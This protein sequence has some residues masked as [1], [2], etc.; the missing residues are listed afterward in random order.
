M[1]AIDQW[2][3]DEEKRRRGNYG[4]S[5]TVDNE[6][7]SPS[8]TQNT[9]QQESSGSAIDSWFEN[10]RKQQEQDKI[11]QELER[12][13]KE[14][15]AKIQEF[16][17][18]LEQAKNERNFLQKIFRT[19][20]KKEKELAE[21]KAEFTAVTF[22]KKYT[23]EQKDAILAQK[24]KDIKL[25]DEQYISLREDVDN[26]LKY[27]NS[28]KSITTQ[29]EESLNNFQQWQVT[30]QFD[31]KEYTRNTP[32][33]PTKELVAQSNTYNTQTDWTQAYEYLKKAAK[34]S[35]MSE[36]EYAR[37]YNAQISGQMLD[38]YQKVVGDASLT[39]DDIINTTRRTGIPAVD[40][41]QIRVE[42]ENINQYLDR[43]KK[44]YDEY[45][46]VREVDKVDN[47][48]EGLEVARDKILGGTA[49]F[50]GDLF[51]SN[52]EGLL[53]I[54]QLKQLEQK[55]ANGE[56]LTTAET[57]RIVLTS[58]LETNQQ[59]DR[60]WKTRVAQ[61]TP[62]ALKM[63]GEMA[64][65][66]GIFNA[67]QTAVKTTAVAAT[68]KISYSAAKEIVEAA[69]SE[70]GKTWI[71]TL[72]TKGAK[73]GLKQ[74]MSGVA[75]AMVAEIPETIAKDS[76]KIATE[77]MNNNR[78]VI[79]FSDP[80]TE[81]EFISIIKNDE[82]YNSDWVNDLTKAFARQYFMN[83]LERGAGEVP[84]AI[85][86]EGADKLKGLII[87][88]YMSQKG[89]QTLEEF[90]KVYDAVGLQG[91]F[92][93]VFEEYAQD[94]TE[95]IID[96]R[97]FI[98][99]DPD[100]F[101]DIVAQV[102]VLQ[103]GRA[104]SVATTV[105]D[106]TK[107]LI[108]GKTFETDQQVPPVGGAAPVDTRV[109]QDVDT[110]ITNTQTEDSIQE[111]L[112]TKAVVRQ[113]QVSGETQTLLT[114]P[115]DDATLL[116]KAQ[117]LSD[118]SKQT[119]YSLSSLTELKKL[120][121]QA[122][123]EKTAQAI[124][125]IS[126]SYAD[127]LAKKVADGSVNIGQQIDTQL[128]D[129]I[130]EIS[131]DE[132]VQEGIKT[133][134]QQI[135]ETPN[136]EY[137]VQEKG[138]F[139]EIKNAQTVKIINEADT[140]IYKDAESKLYQ[141]VEA[142]SGMAIAE[143]STKSTAIEQATA[144]LNKMGVETFQNKIQEA[145]DKK[146]V[147]PRYVKKEVKKVIKKEVKTVDKVQDNVQP[148]SLQEESP[149]E[150]AG[151][152]IG[153]KIKVQGKLREVSEFGKSARDSQGVLVRFTDG[154]YIT[155]DKAQEY[156][157]QKQTK[158][159]VKK[160]STQKTKEAVKEAEETVKKLEKEK[161]VDQNQLAKR[162]MDIGKTNPEVKKISKDLK[163]FQE[164]EDY[165][166]LKD[167][168]KMLLKEAGITHSTLESY[169]D[170]MV[171]MYGEE[172]ATYLEDFMQ[173]WTAAQEIIDTFT[174]QKT[175]MINDQLRAEGFEIP[176]YR[177]IKND[178]LSSKTPFVITN[179][180]SNI[181]K[182]YKSSIELEKDYMI[183][184]HGGQ[185]EIIGGKLVTG[186][187]IAGD[188]TEEN[189]GRG[190]D[191]GGIF[192]T[193][194]KDFASIFTR[195]SEA[196]AG[197]VHTFLVKTKEMFDV[198]NPQHYQKLKDF[199]GKTY[200]DIDGEDLV[201][202][203][204]MLNFMV[205]DGIMDWATFDS[206]VIEAL[207]FKGVVVTE[208]SDYDNGKPLMT[209]VLFE[210]G[211]DS[212]HY[213][214][215]D[216]IESISDLYKEVKEGIQIDI[217]HGGVL[218]PLITF[219]NITGENLLLADKAGGLIAPS[220][221][222]S[223]PTNVPDGFGEITLI[224]GRELADPEIDYRN[225]LYSHDVYSPRVTRPSYDTDIDG[226]EKFFYEDRDVV[227][228]F[229]E[230]D[231]DAYG[232]IE[233]A[234]SDQAK[235]N[236]FYAA[237]KSIGLMN[238]YAK[239]NGI[240]M[241]TVNYYIKAT[242]ENT[243]DVIGTREAFRKEYRDQYEQWIRDSFD[244]YFGEPYV[245]VGGKKLP[246]TAENIVLS[247]F[248]KGI[249]GQEGGMFTGLNKIKG[250]GAKDYKTIEQAKRDSYGRLVSEKEY[251]E[252]TKKQ[253]DDFSKYQDKLQKY[254]RFGQ[255]GYSSILDHNHNLE[256]AMSDYAKKSRT[257][258]SF[259]SAFSRN[260]Y[261]FPKDV[262]E[263][264][265]K[266]ADGILSDPVPY[267][268][269]KL[270]R[271]VNI[272]DFEGALVPDMYR[273][274]SPE[275]EE[276]LKK[277]G[278][279]KIIWL[280]GENIDLE[281]KGRLVNENFDDIKYRMSSGLDTI[282]TQEQIEEIDKYNQK[283]FGDTKYNILQELL[284]EDGQKVYGRYLQ[285][286][287]DI[288]ETDA[289]NNYLHEAA[290]KGFARSDINKKAVL[291]EVIKK[292]GKKELEKKWGNYPNESLAKYL[293]E[294]NRREGH[295]GYDEITSMADI[296]RNLD[297]LRKDKQRKL[298]K[299]DK[300]VEEAK[301]WLLLSDKEVSELNE[302]DR[303]DY[304]KYLKPQLEAIAI[305]GL[306]DGE[307][308]VI[309]SGTNGRWVDTDI[310]VA[311]NRGV[312]A[313]TLALIVKES[314]IESTGVEAKDDR[315]ERLLAYNIF[316]ESEYAPAE[317]RYRGSIY[318][319]DVYIWA[320]E[321]LAENFIDYVQG[322]ETFEGR[323]KQFFD[324]LLE[325]IKSLV[326]AESQ[327]KK[328]YREIYTG[329]LSTKQINN[330]QTN[331]NSNYRA[332]ISKGILMSE[333]YNLVEESKKYKTFE[334]FKNAI[335]PQNNNFPNILYHGT[336]EEFDMFKSKEGKRSYGIFGE[337]IVKTNGMFLTVN[338]EYAKNYGKNV[339]KVYPF[340]KNPLIGIS[341]AQYGE[342]TDQKLKDAN[343]IFEPIVEW[344]TYED[345]NGNKKESAQIGT[346]MI[347]YEQDY[348]G[349]KELPLNWINRFIGEDG[350]ID[351]RLLDN[352]EVTNRLVEKGYDGLLV[353]EDNGEGLSYF[354]PL[355]NKVYTESLLSKIWDKKSF[356][357]IKYRAD[358]LFD[359][360]AEVEEKKPK[361]E[362]ALEITKTPE[363]GVVYDTKGI[364]I[365]PSRKL[366]QQIEETLMSGQSTPATRSV[367][368]F[369][370]VIETAGKI[371]DSRAFEKIQDRYAEIQELDP[372][373]NEL[374]YQSMSI[375][376][377]TAKAMAFVDEY[378]AE[379]RRVALGM[380]LAPEGTTNI[381]VSLAY[382]EKMFEEGKW[383]QAREAD[384]ALSLRGTR[385]GQEIVSFK[386]RL[387][388]NSPMFFM[389]QVLN[390]R[391]MVVSS[392]MFKSGSLQNFAKMKQERMAEVAKTLKQIK[393][394]KAEDFIN[395]LIC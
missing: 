201:F 226:L 363:K 122:T 158:D 381:A 163:D 81:E 137:F 119:D 270:R 116:S 227:D 212:D 165:V 129:N 171:E 92:G 188:T 93:E 121:K 127:V 332:D 24:P 176:K 309:K 32:F 144:R 5:G 359:E 168:Y 244:E 104:G 187:R 261:D 210:G 48:K 204:Q 378:P 150:K 64:A 42:I 291:D 327:V 208:N 340:V 101:W 353:Q 322:R 53:D 308:V 311:L 58:A 252:I 193:P 16:D 1:S 98:I 62:E 183:L 147:S 222:V 140:F 198:R 306:D 28:V 367:T 38:I 161:K 282:L 294:T 125:T 224:G 34:E 75:V 82:E 251:E 285:G 6:T 83:T 278:I 71:R 263:E 337:E 66:Y 17:A 110:L 216:Q 339:V 126:S 60:G 281:S 377:I 105:T 43:A 297:I 225:K 15:Q 302:Y 155:L 84:D 186:G 264:T 128:Q 35:G 70:T 254:S 19:P 156:A 342:L 257:M 94:Y 169:I 141:V 118:I 55:L 200:K 197:K 280:T 203:E 371:K 357:E 344:D 91:I 390:A 21:Q 181:V 97:D 103:L 63:M 159:A 250:L 50:V 57:A 184:Y 334:D 170:N 20:T 113:Q 383:K 259:I 182:K 185:K 206:S 79:S 288:I 100:K 153:S 99:D 395:K 107:N 143:A 290:H 341:E 310:K 174:D 179:E 130:K 164:S 40:D 300:L 299:E 262:A 136:K 248:G 51:N 80:E 191:M 3:D 365:L 239:Q 379:A 45:T 355:K 301:G 268:E 166:A 370:P 279:K 87:A 258:N 362:A 229:D 272:G 109:G 351:W 295:R 23:Q 324:D 267:L 108:T 49:P 115:V 376:D 275:I 173:R 386:G 323:I 289:K 73:E 149:I 388:A 336:N 46:G 13:Q 234:G 236:F 233:E 196:G 78:P 139:K 12:P 292:V 37:S 44:I 303:E 392:R 96:N 372:S 366:Q 232:I 114:E 95:S 209:Y 296:R 54:A 335:L 330:I 205:N 213:L 18:G 245:V 317:A 393:L 135:L 320:E 211:R 152:K 199:V 329:K 39:K 384:R 76:L 304:N 218:N 31:G 11:R 112:E 72:A 67:A 318:G 240:K 368:A 9:K 375:A 345:G 215:P 8:V 56:K 243:V 214:I 4:T 256:Y 65:T 102:G 269:G 194:E 274:K 10:N 356:S 131:P 134:K 305:D 146:G 219:H 276:V 307:V 220:V 380:E 14:Y 61:G 326:G 190:T 358:L 7:A 265:K 361:N 106:V 255:E 391:R 298:T 180:V 346:D 385:L 249:R 2:L 286:W 284:S 154:T 132:T 266:W 172:A 47:I 273:E 145:I 328:L 86:T 382:T 350:G 36:E 293:Y 315:G 162:R 349:N 202:T 364:S 90:S 325:F 160:E 271:V 88:K 230:M 117:A 242:G 195:W 207:G 343:Y 148:E 319:D 133:T 348:T 26:Q 331:Y 68:K 394:E 231:A 316:E 178:K 123:D 111:D 354:V 77:V 277:N 29:A 347:V 238:Y 235:E 237:E 314:E 389:E 22:N 25:S 177:K 313:N 221:A 217:N 157:A 74:V 69:A 247:M 312:S 369:M 360:E 321:E 120:E 283:F 189:L 246:Y 253:Y 333:Y 142:K 387:N 27:L 192:F 52:Q 124:A 241:P 33:L 30:Q 175:R 373:L 352:P 167:E 287:I 151:L 41:N 338:K 59:I 228:A 85:I 374:K 223:K 138:K 260:G 89:I